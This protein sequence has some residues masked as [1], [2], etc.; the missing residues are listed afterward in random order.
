MAVL[1]ASLLRARFAAA[2]PLGHRIAGDGGKHLLDQDFLPARGGACRMDGAGKMP[3]RVQR[4]FEAD[5]TQC[6]LMRARGL[7]HK[8]P[9]H[10]M[11]DEV[12]EGFLFDEFRAFAAQDVETEQDFDLVK[13]LP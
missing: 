6:H 2:G 8:E 4:A 9:D 10:V 11:G 3:H 7:L 5:A 13:S 12:Q 1:R